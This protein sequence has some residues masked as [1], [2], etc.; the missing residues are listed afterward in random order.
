[1]FQTAEKSA[2]LQMRFIVPLIL[3]ASF[4][5]Y[6][7]SLTVTKPLALVAEGRSSTNDRTNVQLV[8]TPN[9]PTEVG[10]SEYS[11]LKSTPLVRSPPMFC[12]T[13]CTRV[14][15]FPV[16]VMSAQLSALPRL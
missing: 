2:R 6:P 16:R 9:F 1:M 4:A 13:F 7:S 10:P 12:S 8:E 11:A 5:R 3:G 14:I 15:E